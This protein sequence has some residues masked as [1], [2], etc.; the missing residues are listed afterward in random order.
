MGPRPCMLSWVPRPFVLILALAWA[1]T[2]WGEGVT[3]EARSDHLISG[4]ATELGFRL[5]PGNLRRWRFS[6]DEPGGGSMALTRGG[7]VL[8]RA[9]TVEAPRTFT[10][11]LADRANPAH[12]AVKVVKVPPLLP[13][14]LGPRADP[15]RCCRAVLSRPSA[16]EVAGFRRD[17]D[18]QE[19]SHLG[20]TN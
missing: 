3:L 14:D 12:T 6:V 10:L 4:R 2:V 8:N 5:E 18:L 11:R 1:V 9:P 7:A 20:R 15:R 13:A 19:A 17:P 16:T